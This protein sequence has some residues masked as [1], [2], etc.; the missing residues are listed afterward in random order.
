M[1]PQDTTDIPQM[2]ADE[3]YREEVFTDRRIGTVR[4]LTPVLR[5][6][7]AD[8]D[9]AVLFSGQAQMMTPAG[10]LPLT[11]DIE[12]D[13]LEDAVAKFSAAAKDAVERTLD[14]LERMQR[15]ASSSIVIPEPGTGGLGGPGGGK[16]QFP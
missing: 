2:N 7:S 4:R 15:E 5:D 11:F 3:L 1:S 10:A 13:S 12:A 9:R 16:I 6:G 8:P 14:E